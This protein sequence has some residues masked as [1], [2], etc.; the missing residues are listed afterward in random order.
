MKT[1][2]ALAFGI[3]VAV[4]TLCATSAFAEP[5]LRTR[6]AVS[7]AI[8]TVGDLFSGAGINA[9]RGL[10]RSPAPGTNGDVS[11]AAVRE[12]AK[13]VGIENFSHEP[14]SSINVERTGV[15]I[16]E[17]T[18]SNLIVEDLTH[19]GI[20]TS[21]VKAD[22]AF[23]STLSIRY[24]AESAHPVRLYNM[25][26]IPGSGSFSAR[27]T[28]EGYVTPLD[29]NGRLS[30]MIDVPHLTQSLAAGAIIRASDVEMRPVQLSF[31]ENGGLSQPGDLIGKE[32]RR[33]A[34][35]GMMLRP[36]DVMSPQIIN[37]SELVTI[38]YQQ[39][40]MRLTIKGQ[41]LNAAAKGEAV[42]VLNLVT[43]KIIHGVAADYGS[44]EM[45]NSSSQRIQS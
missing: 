29:V 40:P 18:L 25:R 41:A 24:A 4:T 39:G 43:K 32:L 1:L 5:A 10:F 19:R 45:L 30:L 16:D 21:G 15:M 3:G 20:I 26:Y 42:S 17:T 35:E 6:I 8:V 27:F 12:A 7:S 28:I 44:V 33:P 9:E 36:S 13:R 2:S 37:R 14:V 31:A 38:Y 11:I 23:G 34:R 22:I